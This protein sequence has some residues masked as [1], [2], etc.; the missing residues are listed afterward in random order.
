MFNIN[1]SLSKTKQHYIKC[2]INDSK[3]VYLKKKVAYK[4]VK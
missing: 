2:P 4:Y 1:L 3:C